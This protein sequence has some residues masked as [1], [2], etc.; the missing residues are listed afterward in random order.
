MTRIAALDM[1]WR[2]FLVAVEYDGK[3]H[4]SDR[5]RYVRDRWRQQR[6]KELGWLVVTV[7]KE[8][9]PDEVI[10]RVRRALIARGWRP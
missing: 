9:C 4:Q 1:G 8:D 10:Q 3:E 2:E 6:L 5:G 7:I